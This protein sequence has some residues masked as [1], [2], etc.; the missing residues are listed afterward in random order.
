[1]IRKL[2]KLASFLKESAHTHEA[3]II[4][5]LIKI[6]APPM[7]DIFSLPNVRINY[8]EET[9]EQTWEDDEPVKDPYYVGSHGN[10]DWYNSIKAMGNSVIMISFDANSLDEDELSA[11]S[12]VFGNYYE[13]SNDF[14]RNTNSF[15]YESDNKLGDR[16]KLKEVFPTLWSKIQGTLNEKNLKEQD[17]IYLLLDETE[18]SRPNVDLS[19]HFFSH[20]IGHIEGDFGE[21]RTLFH[22]VFS[23]LYNIASLYVGEE[24]GDTLKSS[25]SNDYDED[26]Y[27]DELVTEVIS[28]FFPSNVFSGDPSDEVNDVISSALEGN[29]SAEIPNSIFFE[30]ED[31]KLEDGA[32]ESALEII[33]E[34]EERFNKLISSKGNDDKN[35]YQGVL[36]ASKGHVIL[37]SVQ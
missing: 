7:E 22:E 8:D 33:K 11:L 12:Y 2:K 3:N 27:D 16:H 28:D 4:S 17:V 15:S 35:D 1:M 34:F 36:G 25:L 19:P 32:N 10:E 23:F 20:D 5:E 24:S 29:L 6:S 31:Y 26:S 18:S 21:D 14:I 13:D 30:D 9:D 37:Y